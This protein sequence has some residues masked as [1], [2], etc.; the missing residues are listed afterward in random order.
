MLIHVERDRIPEDFTT[1]PVA[2]YG[3]GHFGGIVHR[4]LSG[5]GIKP[6]C[7]IDDNEDIWGTRLGAAEIVSFKSFVDASREKGEVALVL[8]TIYGKQ[9]LAKLDELPFVRAYEMYDWLDDGDGLPMTRSDL[10]DATEVDRL[11]SNV[12]DISSLWADEESRRVMDGIVRYLEMFDSGVIADICTSEEQ[13]LIPEVVDAIRARGRGLRIVDGGAY[14]GELRHVFRKKS[15]PVEKWWCFEADQENFEKLLHH[16]R[17]DPSMEG[18]QIC[19]G[20]GLWSASGS[21]WFDDGRE[22]A[23]KIADRETGERVD[24]VSLDDYFRDTS[25]NFIKMD[26]EGAELEALKGA[27]RTIQEDRPIMAISIYHSLADFWR[28]PQWLAEHLT[29]Y[30]YIVRHHSMVF[31]ETVLYAIPDEL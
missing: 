7:V 10:E 18:I 24:V 17:V 5:R 12:C 3:G 1:M 22:T 31:C 15:L 8:G 27:V 29:G 28:I 20:K 2:I 23:S 13:Y 21:L 26:I 14:R 19:I 30:R 9:V 11:R 4:I 25:C 6:S 16:S